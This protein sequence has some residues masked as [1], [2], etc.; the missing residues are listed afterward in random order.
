MT[1][2]PKARNAYYIRIL[3]GGVHEIEA[4]P[5]ST[6]RDCRYQLGIR[7]GPWGEDPRW[8]YGGSLMETGRTLEFYGVRRRDTIDIVLSMY[9]CIHFLLYL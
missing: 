3:N 5:D 8:L 4:S 9:Y 7:G 6:V 2:P 1:T